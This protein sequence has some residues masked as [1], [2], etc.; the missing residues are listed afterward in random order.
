MGIGLEEERVEIWGGRD[1]GRWESEEMERWRGG[2][3]KIG[4]VEDVEMCRCADW[5][6]WRLAVGLRFDADTQTR[7]PLADECWRIQS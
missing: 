7:Q 3:V 4:D 1:V 6:M 5:K 2:D